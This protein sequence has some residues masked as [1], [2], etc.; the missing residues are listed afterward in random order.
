[1]FVFLPRPMVT[2]GLLQCPFVAINFCQANHPPTVIK[3]PFIHSLLYL[4]LRGSSC[5]WSE[6]STRVG[7]SSRKRIWAQLSFPQY[8][9]NPGGPTSACG[10]PVAR[11][12]IELTDLAGLFNLWSFFFLLHHPHHTR[13]IIHNK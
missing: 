5:Q 6:H 12:L 7:P 1:M 8:L 2:A 13:I 3:P 10:W 9:P 4:F 11:T